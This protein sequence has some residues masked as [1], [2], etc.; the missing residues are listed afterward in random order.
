MANEEIKKELQLLK[1][2]L[3]NN[4]AIYHERMA[5]LVQLTQFEIE[6]TRVNFKAKVIKPLD[7]IQAETNKLYEH[8][9]A[10]DDFSF[11]VSY[12]FGEKENISILKKNKLGGAYCPFTLWLDSELA[13]FVFDN[14]D[15]ITKQIPKYILWSKDWREVKIKKKQL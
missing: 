10:K 14:E 12:L 2:N 6:E 7:K 4:Y 11:N 9:I 1:D 5:L 3:N 15:E 13:R 8:I